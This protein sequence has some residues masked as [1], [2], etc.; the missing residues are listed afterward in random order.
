MKLVGGLV[1]L[2]IFLVFAFNL[3]SEWVHS[4]DQWG[5]ELVK[6]NDFFAPF[7]Y[8][9]E[10]VFVVIVAII[11]LLVLWFKMQNFRAMLFVL[12]TIAG[13]NMI[14][15]L[16][17]KIFQRERP[18]IVNQLTSYSFPSGHSMT[19]IL[20]LLTIAYLVTEFRSKTQKFWAFTIA[21]VLTICIG[22]SRVAEMRHYLSDV[23]SG[24]SLGFTVF[25]IAVFWY[26]GRNRRIKKNEQK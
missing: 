7:H 17:K 23:V 9:G 2:I 14:N 15:L 10:P 26:E 6:G 8:I 16:M 21:I 22:L 24:W 13:G 4:F 19:G 12:I 5:I 20:Y 25:V 11:L 18:D 3:K 1:T